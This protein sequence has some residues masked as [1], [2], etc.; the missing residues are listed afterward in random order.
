MV[1]V[2][3]AGRL[4][5]GWYTM[6]GWLQHKFFL[7]EGWR[8]QRWENWPINRPQ[9]HCR[10]ANIT[11]AVERKH[12]LERCRRM[13]DLLSSLHQWQS[14]RERW[15]HWG[16]H[17]WLLCSCARLLYLGMW[18][19]IFILQMHWRI[20]DQNMEWSRKLFHFKIHRAYVFQNNSRLH[21]PF[22]QRVHIAWRSGHR[23]WIRAWLRANEHR[24]PLDILQQVGKRMW[25][26]ICR[27]Y[28]VGP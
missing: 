20:Q 8:T 5:L 15:Y 2:E 14:L 11:I 9:I 27:S 25:P 18:R 19:L 21:E 4:A 12:K 22:L 26:H 10:C 17:C 3:P 7:V 28:R 6:S 16:M 1:A 24:V 13:V 23:I